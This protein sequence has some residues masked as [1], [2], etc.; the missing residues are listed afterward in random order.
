MK[1]HS[2]DVYIV[3]L[4]TIRPHH[5]AMHTIVTQTIV[6]ACIKN[7][8]GIEGWGEV[9]TIGGASYSEESPEA[10]KL[11]IENYVKPLII[12]ENPVNFDA[13]SYK[14]SQHVKGNYFAKALVE[15]AMVDLVAKTLNIP[16]YELFG[17]QCHE[18]LPVAWTLASGDT[19]K[20]IEEAQNCLATKR[21]NIF[22]LKIGKGDP[23]TNVDHVIKIKEAVGDAGSVRVDVNQAWDEV[24]SL[25]CI[26]ALQNGGVDLIEQPLVRWDNEGMSRLT[27][28]FKVP[29]MADESLGTIQE[30]YQISKLRAGNVFALKVPKA[31]GLTATKKVA[32]IAEASGI[33][34]YGGTMIESSLG[35]AICAQLYSTI[36]ELTFGTELFGPLLFKDNITVNQIEYENFEMKIPSGPG[37]GMEMDREKVKH[38]SRD[39]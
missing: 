29:I 32:A 7:E 2:L 19:A 15:S 28:R 26:E 38:Y 35:T 10:I 1:I 3:D 24:T 6:I 20:D 34:M 13:L 39:I 14:I 23:K 12:G 4:P 22:K 9:A 37:F 31:G 36:P 11:N 27:S 25:Y 18:S 33:P 5:L 16:A 8:D 17:G 30:A 21:H